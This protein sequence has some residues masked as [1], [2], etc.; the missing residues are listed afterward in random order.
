M[1][2][3][4]WY[5]GLGGGNHEGTI[6]KRC[7]FLQAARTS[8]V[9]LGKETVMWEPAHWLLT[10]ISMRVY[11]CRIGKEFDNSGFFVVTASA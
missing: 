9:Y 8:T 2:W 3:A 1:C 6:K 11:C 10:K 7:F 5:E 4:G